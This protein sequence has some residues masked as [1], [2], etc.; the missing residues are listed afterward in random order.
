MHLSFTLF[1]S[2]NCSLFL[3]RLLSSLSDIKKEIR[4]NLLEHEKASLVSSANS[5]QCLVSRIAQDIRNQRK[6]RERRQKE[7]N[8]LQE[9]NRVLANK[10][11]LLKEQ[12]SY[13]NEYVKACLDSL[14]SR[15]SK[16]GSSSVAGSGGDWSSKRKENGHHVGSVKYT[17]AKLY[18]KG[19]VLEIEGLQPNQ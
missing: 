6:H 13:Y 8:H 16:D 9:V 4:Q 12:V 3:F 19:V 7:L 10:S 18:E 2:F 1:F 15:K 11:T 17:G 5:Y 14:N